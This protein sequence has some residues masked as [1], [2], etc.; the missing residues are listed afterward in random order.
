[1]KNLITF[2]LF[3]L[4]GIGA[5]IIFIKALPQAA[6]R[7]PI[8]LPSFSQNQFSLENAPSESIKGKIATL[9]GDVKWQNRVATQAAQIVN[10]QVIQQGEELITGDDGL[11]SVEIPTAGQISISPKTDIS[12]VQT[13]PQN[14]VFAQTKGKAEYLKTGSFPISIRSLSLLIQIESGDIIVSL[15]EATPIVTIE[16]KDGLITVAYN[17]SQNVSQVLKIESGKRFVFNNDTLQGVI[18]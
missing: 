7:Q 6:V 4:I 8:K 9:S 18:K 13:L 1:M 2:I 11:V 10:P 16:V 12:F 15:S 17:D 5:T 14:V 3:A